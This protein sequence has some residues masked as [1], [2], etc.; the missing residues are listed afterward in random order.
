MEEPNVGKVAAAFH[1]SASAV[2]SGDRTRTS[3]RAALT[4]RGQC[5]AWHRSAYDICLAMGVEKLKDTGY[6][7]LRTGIELGSLNWVVWPNATG[8]RSVCPLLRRMPLSIKYRSGAQTRSGPHFRQEHANGAL[9]PKPHLRKVVTEDQ[10]M[11]APIIAHPLGSR[12][13]RR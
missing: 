8:A 5:T 10:V 13:L 7:G 6:G 12:L 2:H 1:D 3:A 4:F 9:T 11:A